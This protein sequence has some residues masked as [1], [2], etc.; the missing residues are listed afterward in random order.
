MYEPH[1][2]TYLALRARNFWT[3]FDPLP[4][5][6]ILTIY[7]A[8]SEDLLLL[9]SLRILCKSRFRERDV[10]KFRIHASA[11]RPKQK[12]KIVRSQ[13]ILTVL[14]CYKFLKIISEG[15]IRVLCVNVVESLVRGG[16]CSE[17]HE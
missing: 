13:Q 10:N 17:H 16:E 2:N 3:S 11:F 4:L 1:A 14:T 5:A 12:Q 6:H 7:T 9:A 15:P 8:S